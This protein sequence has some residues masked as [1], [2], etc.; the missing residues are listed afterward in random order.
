M[1][2]LKGYENGGG[3][4]V[5]SVLSAIA[6][7]ADLE[8]AVE[9]SEDP[10]R[11]HALLELLRRALLDSIDDVGPRE[12]RLIA[13]LVAELDDLEPR[14]DRGRVRW[15]GGIERQ[16]RILSNTRSPSASRPS[17]PST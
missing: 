1:W 6:L 8:R 9:K 15:L 5:A 4:D 14:L 2:G 7:A 3:A 17:R 13:G 11:T 10:V 16:C 12:C